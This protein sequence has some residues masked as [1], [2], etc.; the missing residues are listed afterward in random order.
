MVSNN[1]V[2]KGKFRHEK[3]ISK[4]IAK[5]LDNVYDNNSDLEPG[6]ILPKNVPWQ[7]FLPSKYCTN[8]MKDRVLTFGDLRG[9]NSLEYCD[10]LFIIGSYCINKFD[11][12]QDFSDWFCRNP[13]TMDFVEQEPH[14][15]YYH[16]I[17]KDLEALRW[18]REDYEMF[19][20]IHRIR[21]LRGKKD[22]Y[23]F[24]VVPDEIRQDGLRTE[25]IKGGH[26]VNK[27][28]TEWLVNYAKKRGSVIELWARDD[29]AHAFGIKN[30]T[31]YK[32]IK[33]IAKKSDR[34][35]LV[36]IKGTK[37]LVYG[38]D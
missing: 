10:V 4:A 32:K 1:E 20:A 31:A 22:V 16:Y 37:T 38:D 11:M 19:Q 2:N 33:Q 8:D 14:G 7:Q 24:G 28:E 34:L 18:M 17:D 13:L 36:K 30:G 6:I 12:E 5:I 35:R 9:M 15:D 29:M 23:V 21:P 25:I 3:N 27:I 26:F